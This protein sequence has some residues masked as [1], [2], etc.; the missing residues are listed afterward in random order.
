[1][2]AWSP[3]PRT[4]RPESRRRGFTLIELLAALAIAAILAVIALPTYQEA[5]HRSLRLDAR[6]ALLRI[7]Y[8]QETFYQTHLRYAAQLGG[9]VT[10]DGLATADRSDGGDYM[11]SIAPAEDGQSYAVTAQALALGRQARDRNCQWLA[12]DATGH[13]RS[14]DAAG[15]WTDNDPHRCWG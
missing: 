8:L 9:D 2:R 1:M 11:L 5:V 3:L 13:R 7:Q 6:L 15:T 4:V 12:I 10:T 14:A